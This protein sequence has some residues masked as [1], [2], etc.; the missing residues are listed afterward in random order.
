MVAV[1]GAIAVSKG[2]RTSE[3]GASAAQQK[4]GESA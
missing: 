1:V 4:T 2:K 3:A